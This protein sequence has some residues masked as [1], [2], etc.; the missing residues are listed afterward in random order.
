MLRYLK[1]SSLKLNQKLILFWFLSIV[2]SMVLLGGVFYI[3]QNNLVQQK[4]E[5]R[6][7]R[8]FDL[9][10][11]YLTT[12]QQHTDK[13]SFFFSNQ[14]NIISSLSLLHNYQDV[15]SYQAIIFDQEKKKLNLELIK[16][17][18]TTSAKMISIYDG[19]NRLSSLVYTDSDNKIHSALQSYEKGNKVFY[20]AKE[21]G[22][23]YTPVSELPEHV[24]HATHTP[25]PILNMHLRI[26]SHDGRIALEM[27]MPVIRTFQDGKT[28]KVGIISIIKELDSDFA[29][30]IKSLTGLEVFFSVDGENW[31]SA[32]RDSKAQIKLSSL[33]AWDELKD[34]LSNRVIIKA[35]NTLYGL[36]SY[37]IPGSNF[38][39]KFVFIPPVGETSEVFPLL[40][41]SLVVVL[42]V[43]LFLLLP[44]GVYFLRKNVLFPVSQLVKGVESVREGH[45]EE[46]KAVTGRGE[47]AFLANSF[48]E[49]A[50]SIQHR[51]NELL[52]LSLAVEQ[53]PSS[54]MI[55]D[56]QANFEYVND[57]FCRITGYTKEEVIGK[58][59]S[60]LKGGETPAETYV[61]LWTT[62]TKGEKWQG[63]F[64][65]KTKHG[66]MIWE[67]VTILPIKSPDGEI[68]RYLGINEDITH[69]KKNKKQ[70][71]LQ[72]A[73]LEA[74]ADG[75]VI[76]DI[77]G[78]IQ[79]VNP[80][81]ESLTGYSFSEVYGNNPRVL[82]SGKQ[83]KKFFK[84][85]WDTILSGETWTG[86]LYNKRKD[87]HIYLEQQSITPVFDHDQKI[88]N[89]VAIKRD[90]SQQRKHEKE[91]QQSQKMDALGK[92]TGGVAHD[93]NN[94][95]GIIIGY[96]ELLR[97]KLPADSGLIKYVNAISTAGD[98]G[99][100]LTNKLLTFSRQKS[101]DLSATNIND[102]LN[103]NKL[104][105]EKTL[106]AR[107]KVVFELE[108]DLCNVF[109]DG[110]DFNDAVL[111][112]SINAMH[113]MPGGG[114]L[115]IS[116]SNI[117]L[118]DNQAEQLDLTMGDY[119]LLTLKDSGT[120]MDSVTQQQI[121]EPFFSTKGDK[122]TG[123][124]MSQVYG[125]VKGTNGTIAVD[126]K[127][128]QG[129][130][131]NIYFPCYL[132]D[133]NKTSLDSDNMEQDLTGSES[134]LIV[135]DEVVLLQLTTEILQKQG[136]KVFSAN[137]AKQAL[138]ILAKQE[139]DLVLSDVIM[140]EKDGFQLALEIKELYPK[141]KIQ[142]ISGYND[143]D[144]EVL[145]K[146]GFPEAFKKPIEANVLLKN[147]KN[148]FDSK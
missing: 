8:A 31:G 96:S 86:E 138:D 73:A 144:N 48:N 136:Y 62:I 70:L 63:V 84:K 39:I 99:V 110:N 2:L 1:M 18:K 89:F 87:G 148:I 10:N 17:L 20:V 53:S 123:L 38:K 82:N 102:T 105:L 23:E 139:V 98:R 128:G 40:E 6:I 42:L 108:D 130:Q 45:Y 58:K 101:G 142:H 124:G 115:T 126:S 46:L 13:N 28:L 22:A 113:A 141:I 122:G 50:W 47:L 145:K 4:N 37:T 60:I 91:L 104:M 97:E 15:E 129:T 94:M 119:V 33:F 16:L 24:K 95:L 14:K 49:M 54:L 32:S 5:Q 26:D 107:I 125:F 68:I 52:K 146:Q 61:D 25:P 64:H 131:F 55:T 59:T 12:E 69:D 112:M 77:D 78:N 34:G 132:E 71:A 9:L 76:T 143:I 118:D 147:I 92:L 90:I 140:P 114:Q 72:S 44:I 100:N 117:T 137:S 74:T 7:S 41:G 120:G 36:A 65:N 3:L 135:D 27:Y 57:A 83:E 127:L 21:N 133:E 79:W 30:E 109:L 80:A 35:N 81:Y 67:S 11:K 93:Y 106:T 103:E 111:N 88:T 75:I 134:I 29:K 116:T 66:E 121:F 43:N 56:T 51:E 19:H 85:L